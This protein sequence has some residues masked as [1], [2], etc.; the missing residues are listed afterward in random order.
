MKEYLQE[1][2]RKKGYTLSDVAKEMGINYKTLYTKL[3]REKLL[4]KELLFIANMTNVDLNEM[5]EYGIGFTRITSGS[6][7][8]LENLR[9]KGKTKVF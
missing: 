7:G 1:E 5:V 4:A 9:G 6:S 3:S 2:L 8:V